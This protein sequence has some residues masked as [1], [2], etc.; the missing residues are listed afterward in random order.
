MEISKKPNILTTKRLARIEAQAQDF[1]D[2][3]EGKNPY[4]DQEIEKAVLRVLARIPNVTTAPKPKIVWLA[5][6]LDKKTKLYTEKDPELIKFCHLR[7]KDIKSGWHKLRWDLRDLWREMEVP[8]WHYSASNEEER[9]KTAQWRTLVNYPGISLGT[10]RIDDEVTR[11][12][13]VSSRSRRVVG[14]L[15][16]V[17]VLLSEA[18]G[19]TRFH[20]RVFPFSGQPYVSF[21]GMVMDLLHERSVFSIYDQYMD[22]RTKDAKDVGACRTIATGVYSL[23]PAWN[24][25]I[26]V[27]SPRVHMNDRGFLHRDDG[28][29]MRFPKLNVERFFLGGVKVPREYVMAPAEELPASLVTTTTNVDVRRELVRKI[30]LDRLFEELEVQ[31]LDEEGEYQLVTLRVGNQNLPYLKMKNPSLENTDH[32]EGVPRGTETVQAALA[33]R[34]GDDRRPAIL[35]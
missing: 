11:S 4:N 30:G 28:P 9:A 5:D 17:S 18:E 15:R 3:W 16:D 29:A 26:L 2:R 21:R 10:R 33:W 13:I 25:I 23:I 8:G 22:M 1:N 20:N 14:N 27:E 35:T 34:N 32:V 19:G 12:G 7:S 24:H 31:K 6:L